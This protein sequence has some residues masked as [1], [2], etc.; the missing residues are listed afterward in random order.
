MNK[1]SKI[2]NDGK[3]DVS[4]K[5]QPYEPA[6]NEAQ[7]HLFIWSLNNYEICNSM[8][9]CLIYFTEICKEPLHSATVMPS[10]FAFL[11]IKLILRH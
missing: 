2:K 7:K 4:T 6:A 3:N 10:I 8:F 1:V 9:Y 5:R 11:I